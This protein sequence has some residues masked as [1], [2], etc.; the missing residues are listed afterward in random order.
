[1]SHLVHRSLRADPPIAVR[2]EG[3]YLYDKA[4]PRRSSTAPAAPRS[5]ASAMAMPG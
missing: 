5:P 2:G 4:R 3:I 1:M